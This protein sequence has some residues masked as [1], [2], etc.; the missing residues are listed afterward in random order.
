M[1]TFIKK[2]SKGNI[3]EW[4]HQQFQKFSRGEFEG[5]AMIRVKNSSGKYSLNATAEY[6]REL[7]KIMAEKLGDSNAHVTGALVSALQL[8]GFSYDSVSSAIGIKKYLFDR[9]MSGTEILGLIEKVPKAFFGLSF[10]VGEQ[11]L[12]IQ[13]KSP[14]SA[15]GSSSAK[16]ENAE[17]KIDFCKV[18]PVEKAIIEN[19]I[20]DAEI[21]DFKKIEVRHKFIITEIIIPPELKNEKDFAVVREKAQRKG[22]IIREIDIDGKI[23]KKE[24]DFC[25]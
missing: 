25:A 23:I 2:I 21:K 20:F 4:V 17:A 11:E 6:A 3:D 5:K 16:K 14:K 8:E 9:D 18:K 19:F 10:K 22:K 13:A 1:D 15:K 24:Y 7:V 12:K